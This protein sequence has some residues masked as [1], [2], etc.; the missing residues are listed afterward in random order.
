MPHSTIEIPSRLPLYSQ[1][2][3]VVFPYMLL[4]VYVGEKDSAIFREADNYEKYV[5]FAY[6]RPDDPDSEFSGGRSEIGTLCRVTQIKKLD[7]GRYK[8]SLEGITRLRILDT[9]PA[10]AVTLAHC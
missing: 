9:E 2:E 1:K 3:S 6:E 4:P 5:V 8:V 7:D 10:G